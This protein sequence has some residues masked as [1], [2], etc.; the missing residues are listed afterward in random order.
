MCVYEWM[1]RLLRHNFMAVY[2]KRHISL[3]EPVQKKNRESHRNAQKS[4]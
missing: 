2:K 3:E 4:S 1:E